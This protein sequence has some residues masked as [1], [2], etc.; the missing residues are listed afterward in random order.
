MDLKPSGEDEVQI[1]LLLYFWV[2]EHALNG[3][4]VLGT[5]EI[6]LDISNNVGKF[7]FSDGNNG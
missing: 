2:Q 1:L 7:F 4:V 3:P 5:T 6:F